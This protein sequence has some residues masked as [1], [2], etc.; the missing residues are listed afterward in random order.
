MARWTLSRARARTSAPR[1]N[2]LNRPSSV[3]AWGE[4]STVEE[5]DGQGACRLARSRVA[6]SGS[7]SAEPV[8]YSFS[9]KAAVS[10]GAYALQLG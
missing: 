3:E 8:G 2:E 1:L 10:V 4:R 7:G 5:R 9:S 6:H